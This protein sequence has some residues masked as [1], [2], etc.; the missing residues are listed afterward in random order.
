MSKLNLQQD[1]LELLASYEAEEWKSAEKIKEQKEQGM[2][3]HQFVKQIFSAPD[4]FPD[5][6]A[7][8]HLVGNLARYK[9]QHPRMKFA[10]LLSK[11]RF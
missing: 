5:W 2:R 4:T 1:E 10:F 9:R 7:Q 8:V 6:D 3:I 11:A